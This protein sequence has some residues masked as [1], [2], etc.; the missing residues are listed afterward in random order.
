MRFTTY[1]SENV[2]VINFDESLVWKSN[3]VVK[4]QDDIIVTKTFPTPSMRIDVST[5]Y[6][7]EMRRVCLV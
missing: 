1:A 6:E 5:T 2:I 7:I 3:D 4:W